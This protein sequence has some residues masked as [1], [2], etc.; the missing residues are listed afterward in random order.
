MFNSEREL[1]SESPDDSWRVTIVVATR[2]RSRELEHTLQRLLALPEQPDVVVV[3]NQS[4]DN[5]VEIARAMPRVHVIGLDHNMGAS[6]RNVGTLHAVTPYVAFSDDDSWWQPGAL[7]IACDLL[8]A[9]ERLSL[10]A[11][12]IWVN[13]RFLDPTCSVMA[14]SPL[15]PPPGEDLGSAHR[16]VLGF[17]ACAAVVRRQAF[18]DVGGFAEWLTIGAEEHL[19]S[20]DLATAGWGL[21]YAPEVVA[22]HHPST[23]RDPATR[24][25]LTTRNE[26]WIDCVRRPRSIAIRSFVHVIRAALSDRAVLLGLV[27]SILG[28]PGVL[29]HRSVIPP[30]LESSLLSLGH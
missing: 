3:D 29:R 17:L 13:D 12:S 24:R 14:D 16:S 6:A 18:L 11:P 15:G 5:T 21:C 1:F 25:R 27:D 2:N 26:L 7:T 19:V 8:D 9:D 20:L 30:W 23:S 22:H 28:L 4:N 10:I